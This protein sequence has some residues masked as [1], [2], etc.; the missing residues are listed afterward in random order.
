MTALRKKMIR[1]LDQQLRPHFHLHA[2]VTG[3]AL[4]ADSSKWIDAG[5]KFLFPVKALSKVFRAKYVEG[6]SRLIEQEEVD[7]PPQLV[8]ST[9][10]RRLLRTLRR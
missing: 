8:D 7:L 9:D 4:S 5:T 6:L 1:E 10:Q 2:M 3:G